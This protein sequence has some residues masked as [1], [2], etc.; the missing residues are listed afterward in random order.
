LPEQEEDLQAAAQVGDS[1]AAAELADLE[2]L[3][4]KGKLAEYGTAEESPPDSYM[5][6]DEL[7]AL[8]EEGEL[9]MAEAA[10]QL[11]TLGQAGESSPTAEV[12]ESSQAAEKRGQAMVTTPVIGQLVPEPPDDVSPEEELQ[13]QLTLWPTVEHHIPVGEWHPCRLVFDDKDRLILPPGPAHNMYGFL[14]RARYEVRQFDLNH[15]EVQPFITRPAPGQGGPRG[16]RPT[17][18]F[19]LLNQSFHQWDP[20]LQNLLA[21]MESTAEGK[22]LSKR[23][24]QWREVLRFRKLEISLGQL[25][26][27]AEAEGISPGHRQ[28]P[29][30]SGFEW[31]DPV[32]ARIGE[33]LPAL[34]APPAKRMRVDSP[35]PEEEVEE[36]A[37]DQPAASQSEHQADVLVEEVSADQQPVARQPAA[38]ADPAAMQLIVYNAA[39]ARVAAPEDPLTKVT[40]ELQE[41]RGRYQRLADMYTRGKEQF[42]ELVNEMDSRAFAHNILVE[43]HRELE[44][45]LEVE[46]TRYDELHAAYT[47]LHAEQQI[48]RERRRRRHE[49]RH[50]Q[51]GEPSSSLLGGYIDLDSD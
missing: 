51:R 10:N 34:T 41:L 19:K 18:D 46:R 28:R 11:L 43:I 31:P 50:R 21:Q 24:K 13:R 23:R 16:Q 49:Q 40:R 9:A 44:E 20:R 35:Q 27:R 12:G 2:R 25:H 17:L 15:P 26:D 36:S 22:A 39:Q 42:S 4:K 1:A 45:A 5:D 29:A 47:A 8:P 7:Y 30:S 38:P 6:E 37:A 33:S 3:R 48:R 14:T 32:P